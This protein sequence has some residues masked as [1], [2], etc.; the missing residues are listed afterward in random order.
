M[1]SFVYN[2]HS[3]RQRTKPM[4]LLNVLPLA[5]TARYKTTRLLRAAVAAVAAD[6]TSRDRQRKREPKT[7]YLHI[8]GS[9]LPKASASFLFFYTICT[10]GSARPWLTQALVC[11]SHARF[12]P[13]EVQHGLTQLREVIVVL[14]APVVA[15]IAV[16]KVHWPAISWKRAET[17]E[18]SQLS[19]FYTV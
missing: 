14:P 6:K 19:A 9:L 7:N 16:I 3:K 11:L 2:A 13:D 10:D 1:R 5:Q 17:R 15:C 4:E 8:T 12:C 18:R